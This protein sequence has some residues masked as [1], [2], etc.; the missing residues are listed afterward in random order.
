MPVF[1]YRGYDEKGSSTEGVIEA[2]GQRDA[3]LKIKTKGIFP[4]EITEA[5]SPGKKILFKKFSPLI[6]ADITR[7]LSIL[8]SSGV[9]LI[10]AITAL[11]SEQKDEWRNLLTDIKEQLAGGASLARAMQEHSSIFPEF[12]TGMIAAGESSG[13][14]TDVLLKL[15]DFLESEIN[16][17]NRVRTALIY[18]I[19]MACVSIVIVLFLFTFVIPK[20]TKIF[21]ETSSALPIST[22]IIIWISAALKKFWWLLIALAAG[23]VML[24]KK[25]MQTK[26]E[27]IDA[28]LLKE[29]TG[30]LM[31]L[32]MLR[33]SMTM[34]FLLSGGL[35]ILRAMQ[36]T[37]KATGNVVLENRITAARDMVSQGAKLSTSLE[38][39]PPTLLQIISTGEQTGKLPEVLEKTAES[40]SAEF[41]RKLQGVISLL[42]PC[43]ILIMGLVVG[44]IVVSVLLP[45]FELNEIMR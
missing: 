2:D 7:R 17:K 25:I 38:G 20:I 14:L 15:A 9:P 36:L 33:F 8:L 28:I 13:K 45:I 16:I 39:F 27:I 29:P 21:E 18:P 1:K 5:A 12:Y 24:Y 3:A 37:S 19:F 35:P 23:V 42:E 44:F 10:E 30:I 22:V 34:G 31:G 11:S 32:Y 40:Y 43:L 41:D 6:L 4:K 26:K